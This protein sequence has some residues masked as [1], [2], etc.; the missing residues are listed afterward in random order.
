MF[1]DE[2]D[3]VK[4]GE[5]PFHPRKTYHEILPG[6]PGKYHAAP[7]RVRDGDV[8]LLPL[9]LVSIIVDKVY[10]AA[11]R[12]LE[13]RDDDTFPYIKVCPRLCGRI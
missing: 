11:D 9:D 8:H 4:G 10:A 12:R 5:Q 2:P 3:K 7:V 1:P 6:Q 13:V